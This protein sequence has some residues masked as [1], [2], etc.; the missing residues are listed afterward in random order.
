MP[1][2]FQVAVGSDPAPAIE[3]DFASAN[4]HHSQLSGE[5]IY[6]AGTNLNIGTFSIPNA[7]GVCNSGG[8]GSVFGFVQRTQISI[9]GGYLGGYSMQVMP[10]V[11]VTL[12]DGGDYY[13][14]FAGGATRGQKV[15]VA[16]ATGLGIAGAAG[17]TINGAVVTGSITGTVLTVTAVTSGTVAVG[18]AVTGTGVTAGT[19]I[20][21]LG[22]GT[23]GAGTYTVNTSQTVASTTLTE[24]GASESQWFVHSTVGTNELARISTTRS[25]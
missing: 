3:G 12:M 7:A 13:A 24:I 25:S 18:Q 11:E 8:V 6:V 20:T 16:P 21:A 15:F 10:G 4:P 19:L 23:G 14:R 22:S 1:F 17:A 2:S 5:G 9:I